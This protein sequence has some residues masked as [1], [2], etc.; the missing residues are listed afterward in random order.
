MSATLTLTGN[1]A[2]VYECI[3]FW[4]VTIVK[5]HS[6]PKARLCGRIDVQT[7]A[8]VTRLS[9]SEIRGWLLD[10]RID[11]SLKQIRTALAGLL[12]KGFV[13][14]VQEWTQCWNRSYS[15]MPPVDSVREFNPAMAGTHPVP[16]PDYVRDPGHNVPP[17][18]EH[19]AQPTGNIDVPS[20]AH[21]SDRSAVHPSTSSSEPARI[22]S[23]AP[24]PTEP[25]QP[26]TTTAETTPPAKSEEPTEHHQPTT[27]TKSSGGASHTFNK[28]EQKIGRVVAGLLETGWEYLAGSDEL[29]WPAM[30]ARYTVA[31]I[32]ARNDI[33]LE[34][35]RVAL[36][37]LIGF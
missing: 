11:L 1:E 3:R 20:E 35:F 8:P 15:Y 4:W 14:R 19:P 2:T 16:L 10:R 33:P 12:A 22:A 7:G 5:K 24:E 28:T 37:P 36:D 18:G 6:K 32:A 31:E 25:E 13:L 29:H 9:A 21:L 17:Q 34:A 23:L 26:V 27:E 30:D